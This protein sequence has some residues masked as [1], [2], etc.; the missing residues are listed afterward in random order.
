MAPGCCNSSP[1]RKLPPRHS[2]H[3][4]GHKSRREFLNATSLA[5]RALSTVEPQRETRRAVP[6]LL[7]DYLDRRR[8][9]IKSTRRFAPASC[10][11]IPLRSANNF[12]RI[13]S[14]QPENFL[15]FPP[16]PYNDLPTSRAEDATADMPDR[17]CDDR[18]ISPTG[19][20]RMLD[21]ILGCISLSDER[22]LRLGCWRGR[23]RDSAVERVSER[24]K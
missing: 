5:R 2:L 20:E 15:N 16:S 3:Q 10:P 17:P 13:T 11:V 19:G 14:C 21:V 6:V 7:A 18:S 22:S 23:R 12:F 4:S 24:R 8:R 9:A 1:K